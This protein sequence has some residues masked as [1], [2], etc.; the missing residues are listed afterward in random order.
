MSYLSSL[1]TKVSTLN[2]QPVPNSYTKLDIFRVKA[3]VIAGFT[4][5]YIQGSLTKT[6]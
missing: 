4:V 5:G 6:K 3:T 2:A 1:R